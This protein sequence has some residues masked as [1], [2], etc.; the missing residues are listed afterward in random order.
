MGS[1][2]LHP[3]ELLKLAASARSERRN[4]RGERC[5]DAGETVRAGK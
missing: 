2:H 3:A 4:S 5:V 1:C